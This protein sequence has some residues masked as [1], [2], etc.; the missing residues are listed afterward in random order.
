MR[1]TYCLNSEFTLGPV[2]LDVRPDR[3]LDGRKL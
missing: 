1:L 3:R 2:R